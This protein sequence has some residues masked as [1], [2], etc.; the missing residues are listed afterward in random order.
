[1][2]I[3]TTGSAGG[4]TTKNKRH[5]SGIACLLERQF[6]DTDVQSLEVMRLRAGHRYGGGYDFCRVVSAPILV[7]LE[8]RIGSLRFRLTSVTPAVF[9][10]PVPRAAPS[11]RSG[12]R[13]RGGALLLYVR[14]RLL[15][16]GNPFC[17]GLLLSAC[18]NPRL[19]RLLV[20]LTRRSAVDPRSTP[21]DSR[22]LAV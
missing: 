20:A 18:G 9:P 15:Q 19:V 16:F 22:R 5:R 17:V 3:M 7:S 14:D 11:L 6:L 10:P 8:L 13:Q 4:H 21:L 12:S 1:M 2:Q